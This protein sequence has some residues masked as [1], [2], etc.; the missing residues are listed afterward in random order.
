M[1]ATII[2]FIQL[3]LQPLQE[4]A[5]TTF[6]RRDIRGI[7]WSPEMP[8]S[9]AFEIKDSIIYYPDVFAEYKCE[10]KSDSLLVYHDDG[11]LRSIVVKL[12]TDTLVLSTSGQESIYTRSETKA[13]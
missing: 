12:T 10:L 3:F 6:D 8:Q 13:R 9:A 5:A 4:K 7:W 2:I 11:V 1:S